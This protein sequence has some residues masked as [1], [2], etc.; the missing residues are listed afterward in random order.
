[1]TT[2]TISAVTAPTITGAAIDATNAPVTATGGST[3]G[4]RLPEP[5]A[6]P[7]GDASFAELAM[8]LTQADEQDRKAS[9]Q[10]E[11]AADQAAAEQDSSRVVQMRAKAQ[12]DVNSALAEGLGEVVG[13]LSQ[14]GVGVFHSDTAKAL[15]GGGAT[16]A[17]GAGKIAGG[18]FRG[19]AG[20]RDA[21][22]AAAEAQGQADIRRSGQAHED[23]QAASASLD[24]VEQFLDQVMQTQNATRLATV[25]VRG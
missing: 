12:D 19:D 22:A 11:V 13:G 10:T 17:T 1:M 9:R 2:N 3:S 18:A 7:C 16:A 5:A 20:V 24:K 8:L 23:A 25:S 4:A 21:D 15:F 6:L 14:C